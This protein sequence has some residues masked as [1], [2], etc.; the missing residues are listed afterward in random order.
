MKTCTTYFSDENFYNG[1]DQDWYSDCEVKTLGVYGFGMTCH[2]L[3]VAKRL[4]RQSRLSRRAGR[5]SIP[6]IDLI[7]RIFLFFALISEKQ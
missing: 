5:V 6:R 7:P 1:D 3:T 2:A 4:R